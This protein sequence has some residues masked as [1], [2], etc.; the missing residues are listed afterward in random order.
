MWSIREFCEF[1]RISTSMFKKLR[2]EG[3]APPVVHLGRRVL[4]RKAA[5]DKWIR[6]LEKAA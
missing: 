2:R 6:N 4:I 3:L 1:H 5:A